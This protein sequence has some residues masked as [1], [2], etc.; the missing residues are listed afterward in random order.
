MKKLLIVFGLAA[1]IIPLGAWAAVFGPG[2]NYTLARGESVNANLYA[3]GGNVTVLGNAREDLIAGGG[4]VMIV[5][6]VGKDANLA[7]GTIDIS[8]DVG[9][10]LRAA[11]G[12]VT[13]SG[14]VGGELLAAAGQL[15]IGS[16][17]QIQGESH[18][19]GGNIVVDGRLDKNLVVRG[20]TIVING[21]I[22]GNVKIIASDSLSL[23]S[24]AVIKG[25]LEYSAPKEATIA[26]GAK[27]G[28]KTDF[29]K[30]ESIRG[31]AGKTGFKAIFGV[32]WLV[33]T[34]MMLLAALVVSLL[35]KKQ[36]T[37]A[38][39]YI[40]PNFGKEL[41]RG[42]IIFVVL[43]IAI[44]ISFV[45]VVGVILGVSTTFLY[46]A[47]AFFGAI[48][49]QIVAGALITKF[50]FK[51]ANYEADWKAA[52]IGTV[53]LAIVLLIPFVGGLVCF[54]FFL[55]AFGA[56]FNFLY[57]YFADANN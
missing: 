55:V 30:I 2:P 46:I 57:R 4:T 43:P 19:A 5:G 36:A 26:S 49:A 42:F 41:L 7:G 14:K 13:L 21:I 35:L 12:N 6:F 31:Y 37:Q 22:N 50:V 24:G 18:L 27:I 44:I 47:M 54:V 39:R 9:D 56:L 51:Q 25:N 45:T 48:M 23:G 33:R 10:D 3:G 20:G 28:G 38:V 29:K 11:G 15:T 40:M 1:L 53:A 16:S 52:V 8:G 17:A 34:L 32:A